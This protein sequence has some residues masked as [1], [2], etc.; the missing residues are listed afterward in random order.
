MT[1]DNPCRSM[2]VFIIISG[3]KAAVH[4]IVIVPTGGGAKAAGEARL[5]RRMRADA[6]GTL[7]YAKRIPPR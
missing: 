2:L 5:R 1:W 3:R 7:Q 6:C 4:G